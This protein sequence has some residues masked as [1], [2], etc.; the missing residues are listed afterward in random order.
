MFNRHA[1]S[2]EFAGDDGVLD[3]DLPTCTVQDGGGTKARVVVVDG[4]IGN[5]Q[6]ARVIKHATPAIAGEVARNGGVADAHGALFDAD[7]PA[8][9]ARRVIPQQRADQ[10]HRAALVIHGGAVFFGAAVENGAVGDR[11]DA[12]LV[13]NARA[14]ATAVTV[15]GAVGSSIGQRDIV[16]S[17]RRASVHA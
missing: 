17:Q 12:A 15:P 11:Y 2:G 9:V 1:G 4:S 14:V 16:Q 6:G 10:A 5:S 3:G 8:V 7:C 13:Q